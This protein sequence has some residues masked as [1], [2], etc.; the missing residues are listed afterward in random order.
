[1][2]LYSIGFVHYFK[3]IGIHDL[4][5]HLEKCALCVTGQFGI[6]YSMS[7]FGKS[8]KLSFGLIEFCG[9]RPPK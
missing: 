7:P 2:V 3:H 1:M 5:N 6:Y 4:V 9:S 8:F